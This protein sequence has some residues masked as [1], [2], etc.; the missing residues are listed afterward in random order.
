MEDLD[1]NPLIERYQFLSGGGEMGALTRAKDWSKTPVGLVKGW[2]QSLR[3]ALGIV[4]NSKFPMFLW[5][6]PQLICFYNDAYRPSLGENGKHP[7]ILGQRAEEAW[8]E[9]WDII[10]PLIEQVLN[11]GEATWSEDQLI[12]I[13]R[14]GKI[15]D[16][17]WTFS[18]SP[19]NDES[20]KVAGVLVTCSETT[21]KVNTLKSLE[22]S[23]RRYFNNIMQAPVA[24]CIF[25]GESHTVEIANELM[26][27]LWGKSAEQVMNKPIF[28]GLPEAR[29]QGLEQLMDNVYNTGKKF[30]ANERPVKLPRNGK[31]E[32]IYINFVYEAF[33]EPDGA[34]S[35]IVAIASEVTEQVVARKKVENSEREFRQLADSL[36]ALV[37]TTDTKGIQTFASKKWKEFTGLDPYDAATFEKMVHPADLK[38]IIKIWADCLASGEIYKTEVRL[39]SKNGDYQWF[40]VNGE[41]VKNEKGEIKKWIGT[42]T[43]INEQKKTEEHLTIAFHKVEESEKRFRNTVKQAPLGIVIFRGPGFIIEMANTIMFEKI[44]RQKEDNVLGKK[45]LDVFRELKGQKYP[46]LLHKVYSTGKPHSEIE[47][48]TYIQGEDGLKKFYFDFEY[49]PLFESE[50]TIS[51]I[52]VTAN[53]VTEKV[54]ARQL[55]KESTERLVLATEG[56]QL[57]TWDLNLQTS[58]IIHSPRLSQIFGYPDE[59]KILT[60]PQMR[61]QIH[62][63]DIHTVVEKAFESALQTGTYYY[64]SRIIHPDKTI[65]WIRTRGKVLFDDNGLPVR[66]LGTLI[67]ITDSQVARENTVRMAA[68][69]HSSDDAI[70][71]KNM[72]GIITTWNAGAARIFGYNEEEMIG[73]PITKL[74]PADKIEEET[75][76]LAR[77]K[78]GER[79]EHFETKRITKDKK[80]LDVSLTISPLQDVNGNIIGASKIARDVTKQKEAERLIKA[81]EEKFRLLA[82][83]MPQFVWTG[84]AEGNLNYFN[85]SVFDYSGLTPEQIN[86]DGWLQIVHPDD[87]EENIKAWMHSVNSG[88]DF[89]FEHRFRRDDGE[90]R[91]QLS[92]AIPQKDANGK[93][94]M[95]VGTSTDIHEIK[96]LDQQKDYFISMASHELKT[97]I[98]SMKGYVQILQSMHLNSDDAFLKKSLGIIDK[99]IVT[100]TKLISELLDLSKIKSGSLVLNK[101]HF[102]INELVQEVVDEIKHI[103][104]DYCFTFSRET[105]TLAYADRE[106]IGQVVI[107]FLTNAVKYSPNSREVKIETGIEDSNIIVSVKDSGIGINK[108]DQQ[109]IFERFYRVEG[110][111]ER[112]FPGFGIGLFI[113]AEII[114]RHGGKIGVK[115]EPGKGSVFYFLLPFDSQS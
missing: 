73:Q 16:V 45:L 51:G 107:N 18:Y 93:I 86:K 77:L 109:K 103:N 23:N 113:A 74:I 38:S 25:R 88:I 62:P 63:D 67:D 41:P 37:W 83:S 8:P 99:Q 6:G 100:L 35:G 34:I 28:E 49:A 52:I 106:R 53:D 47:S 58:E 105:E 1:I 57:A 85:K 14:N 33:K 22:E 9:I 111:N 87:R 40:Y 94:Q 10:K 72:N 61:A 102:Q 2:P 81:S 114:H 84:D 43:N 70:I 96:E 5:W 29:G 31:I 69:V 42:F 32:N 64:Q 12:P 71:S 4:L 97:P 26:M 101:K 90:Y 78:K 68:I 79:V 46:E 55:L 36:P 91:W 95:W 115:S 27:E 82:N 13:Y 21:E 54:E 66:M 19:V 3:T 24:M 98:T 65:H 20:G 76:I 56:T 48:L 59:T 60:H 15:E 110:K 108:Q 112:T 39:R 11:G 50:G 104:P 75:N 89:N 80:I 44:W 30:I 17:Y 92:R 7:A